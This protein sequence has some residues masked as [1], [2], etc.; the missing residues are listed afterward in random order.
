MIKNSK[1]GYGRLSIGMHWL[2]ALAFIGMYLLGDYMVGLD[3]YDSWYHRAPEI[4]KGIGILLALTMLFRFIWNRSQPRPLDLGDKALHNRLAHLAHNLFYLMVLL[5]LVTGYLI[6]TA[7][8]K[9]I[10]VFELFSIP[11]VLPEN[12]DRGEIAGDIHEIIAT[13]FILLAM[14][15]A[16]AAIYHHFVAK[17]FT[18][19][20]M[21][22]ISNPNIH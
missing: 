14:L 1:H 4:H 2:M 10:D 12:P 17:D 22:G 20:R 8:G 18:L 15:H 5:L 9:G 7:K 3:Y 19:K 16:V 21:L 11:A 6:S 13:I